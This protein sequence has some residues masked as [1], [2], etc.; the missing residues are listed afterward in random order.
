MNFAGKIFGVQNSLKPN[1][2]LLYL[3]ANVY[4]D[5]LLKITF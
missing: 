3:P 2:I 1:E 4:F 5:S